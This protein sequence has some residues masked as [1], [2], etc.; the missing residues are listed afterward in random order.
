VVVFV[1]AFRQIDH[2]HSALVQTMQNA[3]LS[4]L[5]IDIFVAGRG[6]FPRSL[7]HQRLQRPGSAA[8]VRQKRFHLRPDIGLSSTDFVQILGASVAIFF[9]RRQEDFFNMAPLVRRHSP[10]GHLAPFPAS[11]R[12]SH[13]WPTQRSR[14]TVATET[15]ITSE[16]SSA[17]IPPKYFISIIRLLRSS[18]EARD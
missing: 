16:I 2:A 4:D 7:I 13:A 5:R 12:C 9:Q 14:P 3:I 6:E 18:I 10:R 8:G 17:V 1:G 15:P 11:S